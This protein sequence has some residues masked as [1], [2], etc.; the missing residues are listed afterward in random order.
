Q[1]AQRLRRDEQPDLRADAAAEPA[2]AV[3]DGQRR[4]AAGGQGAEQRGRAAGEPRD[5]R[6]RRADRRGQ[7]PGQRA[8]GFPARP[9]QHRRRPH[10][11]PG[12]AGSVPPGHR[13][14]QAI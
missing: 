2:G 13:P 12:E 7:Q 5:Q 9:A 14:P 10:P 6:R 1:R 8:P 11:D 3:D 4:E